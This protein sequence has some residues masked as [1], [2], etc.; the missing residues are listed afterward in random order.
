MDDAELVARLKRFDAQSVSWIVE[1][2]GTALH[3][4]VAAIVADP[5]LAEDIVAE[6]YMRMLE[7]IGD[8]K[9][10]GAPFRAWLYRIAHNLAINAV[11]RDRSA[12]GDL[13]LA[14]FEALSGNPVETFERKELYDA[15]RQSLNTLT[16]EQREVVLLRFVA[17]LSI[18]EVAQQLQRSEGSVKQLQL[19]ALRALGRLLGAAE[20][21]DG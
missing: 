3:R 16:D 7:R 8:Y 14:P 1:R 13:T 4:Y 6:T 17:G 2:Y 20:V 18:T 10:T 5:H 15:L 9:V 12:P 11:T 21:G 19:R